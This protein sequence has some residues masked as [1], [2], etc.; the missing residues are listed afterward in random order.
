MQRLTCRSCGS[1]LS[2]EDFDRRKAILR[3]R[4]CETLI[5]LSRA[6]AMLK[7]DGREPPESAATIEPRAVAALPDGWTIERTKNRLQIGFKASDS[8]DM[9]GKVIRILRWAAA[10]CAGVALYHLMVEQDSRSGL[11]LGMAAL[12]CL[13]LILP[14]RW[15]RRS[16]YLAT[17]RRYLWLDRWLTFK[18]LI[19]VPIADIAQLYVAEQVRHLNVGRV[20][21]YSYRIVTDYELCVCLRAKHGPRNLVIATFDSPRP[22]LFLEQI[23]EEYLGIVDRSVPGEVKAPS[24][25]M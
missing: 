23:F 14:L 5:D 24:F 18:P 9:C 7:P 19:R 6:P 22:A 21:P 1:T 3:C 12:V 16:M 25:A 4:H 11:G 10:L 2:A 17:D 8:E 15:R 13:A 20:S